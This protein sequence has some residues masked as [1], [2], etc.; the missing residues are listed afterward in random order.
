MYVLYAFFLSCWI[1]ELERRVLKNMLALCVFLAVQQHDCF[2]LAIL[3]PLS[4]TTQEDQ[5]TM[6]EEV[7]NA[8]GKPATTFNSNRREIT[9]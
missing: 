7:Q 8:K 5:W 6:S 3:L 4:A 9:F 1:G 2:M